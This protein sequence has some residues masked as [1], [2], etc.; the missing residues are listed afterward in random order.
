MTP[1]VWR[2]LASLPSWL[3][4]CSVAG[5]APMALA[6]RDRPAA[7]VVAAGIALVGVAYLL[8]GLAP[9]LALAVVAVLVITVGEML[10]K[11]TATAYAADLAPAGMTGRYQSAYGAASISGTMPTPAIGGPLYDVAPAPV[12]PLAGLLALAAAVFL[13]SSSRTSL[14]ASPR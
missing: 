14:T 11:P 4:C 10:Y 9:D 8:L 6:L 2:E 5:E 7:P 13:Y 3:S 12:W 1:A